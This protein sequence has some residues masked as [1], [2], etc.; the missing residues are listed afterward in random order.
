MRLGYLLNFSEAPMKDGIEVG[1]GREQEWKLLPYR[2][3][4]YYEEA[5]GSGILFRSIDYIRVVE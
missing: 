3:S 4:P 2:K 5:L 1:E